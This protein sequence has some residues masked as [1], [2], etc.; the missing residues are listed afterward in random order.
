[1]INT[2]A[3][4]L[5]GRNGIVFN[6]LERDD[7]RAV[8]CT[9]LANMETLRSRRVEVQ[10]LLGGLETFL[11]RFDPAKPSPMKIPFGRGGAILAFEY[12][13]EN[14]A[15][16]TR[17]VKLAIQPGN[18]SRGTFTLAS[19]SVSMM[20]QGLREIQE[21][22]RRVELII[23]YSKGKVEID[24]INAFDH[25][26]VSDRWLQKSRYFVEVTRNGLPYPIPRDIL[27]LQTKKSVTGT[28]RSINISLAPEG[29]EMLYLAIGATQAREKF[30]ELFDKL[31][32]IRDGGIVHLHGWE[33][34]VVLISVSP[35]GCGYRELVITAAGPGKTTRLIRPY[36]PESIELL[37]DI[38]YS[39]L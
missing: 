5:T 38:F 37:K 12:D 30:N 36:T 7:T 31:A 16:I 34:P 8:F 6:I 23:G 35:V 11:T 26:P 28:G 2:I 9:L 27:L 22:K 24:V 25:V 39:T 33:P 13:P 4:S 17:H 1:M 20:E 18:M 21:L 3:F 29:A 14:L 19:F 10:D 32:E 15:S